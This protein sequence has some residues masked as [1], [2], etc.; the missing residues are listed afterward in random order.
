MNIPTPS[1]IIAA[2]MTVLELILLPTT[3][4]IKK[5]II[6]RLTPMTTFKKVRTGPE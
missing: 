6:N 5:P 1:K 4:E 2:Q 3:R